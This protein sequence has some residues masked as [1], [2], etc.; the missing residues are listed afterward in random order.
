MQ[1]CADFRDFERIDS[2]KIYDGACVNLPICLLRIRLLCLSQVRFYTAGGRLPAKCFGID[3]ANDDSTQ[4]DTNSS[5]D[6]E[7]LTVTDS[8]DSVGDQKKS[9]KK[10]S[11]IPGSAFGGFDIFQ[12]NP[13]EQ[14]R[15]KDKEGCKGCPQCLD[16]QSTPEVQHQIPT[17]RS[18]FPT[19]VRGE[20]NWRQGTHFV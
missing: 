15:G 1:I 4:A 11:H 20:L 5:A 19:D 6:E 8:H 13:E 17:E 14:R 16:D 7:R 2:H 3:F 12:D 10:P 18:G 9:D